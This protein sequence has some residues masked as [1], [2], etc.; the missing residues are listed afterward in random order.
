MDYAF[1]RCLSRPPDRFESDQIRS[2]YKAQM[3]RVR[4]GGLTQAQA[5]EMGPVP[6]GVNREELLAWTWVA[7]VP[8]NLDRTISKE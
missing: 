8:L 7:R 3:E 2:Y 5:S 6:V 1:R 4:T